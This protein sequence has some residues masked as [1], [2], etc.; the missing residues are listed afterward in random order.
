MSIA[1]Y[2]IVTCDKCD[3]E[4]AMTVPFDGEPVLCARH[5]RPSTTPPQVGEDVLAIDFEDACSD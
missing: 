2:V 1:E 5:D 3:T 4:L